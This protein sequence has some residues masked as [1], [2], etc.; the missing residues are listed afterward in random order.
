MN[1]I[2][3]VVIER[4]IS[5]PFAFIVVCI[6]F[7][8][9]LLAMLNEVTELFKR[10]NQLSIKHKETIVE[11]R[12]EAIRQVKEVAKEGPE[13]ELGTNEV[14]T[15]HVHDDAALELERQSIRNYGMNVASVQ[16][17]EA[18]VRSELARVG[19]E[20]ND[21]ETADILIRQY[22]V[23]YTI[24]SF[25]KAYRLIF[26][27]QIAAVE[28][29]NVNGPVAENIL[30]IFYDSVIEREPEFYATFSFEQWLSF[31]LNHGLIFR[32]DAAFAISI[33]GKDFLKWLV[34]EGLPKNKSL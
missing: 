3:R 19:F 26:G 4:V 33:I 30:R 32:N 23:Q 17:R 28:F 34:D 16:F 12:T 21:T 22:S 29:A 25:E 5:W 15:D 27:S 11:A 2:L 8:K 6:A 9:P 20:L 14:A 10:I 18:M 31:L 24:S 7:R 1:D 13:G